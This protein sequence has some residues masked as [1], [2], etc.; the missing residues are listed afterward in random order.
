MKT[1]LILLVCIF[2]ISSSKEHYATCT[3]YKCIENHKNQHGQVVGTLR[4]YTP[5]EKG[6]GAGH[7]FWDYE[8]LLK[9]SIAI[10]V[11]VK[12]GHKL[13]LK[14][15]LGKQVLIKCL[16]YYGAIIGGDTPEAQAATGWQ[17]R[18]KSINEVK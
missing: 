18:A 13:D 10:P 5:N 7:M 6:K 16:F 11:V 3:T 12:S 17:I 8:I 9:D 15:F 1:I 14:A 2:G 4:P